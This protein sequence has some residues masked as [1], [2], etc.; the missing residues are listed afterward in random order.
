MELWLQVILAVLAVAGTVLGYWLSTARR[1]RV[2]RDRKKLAAHT[3]AVEKGDAETV[4]QDLEELG[5]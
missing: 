2:Q 3:E 4:A 1:R 5:L